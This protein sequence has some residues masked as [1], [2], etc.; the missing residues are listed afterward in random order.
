MKFMN[1]NAYIVAGLAEEVRV[2]YEETV[3]LLGC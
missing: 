1:E 3:D 2:V